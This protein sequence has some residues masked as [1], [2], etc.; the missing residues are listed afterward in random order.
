MKNII[1]A[2]GNELLLRDE[3]NNIAIIPKKLRK[4]VL[5]HLKAGRQQAIKAIIKRLPSLKNKAGD[6]GVVIHTT[7]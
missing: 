5:N 7:E 3:N 2:E 4:I 1:T 6:G